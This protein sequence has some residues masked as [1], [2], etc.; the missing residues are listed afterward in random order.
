M[1]VVGSPSAVA[2]AEATPEGASSAALVVHEVATAVATSVAPVPTVAAPRRAVAY[3]LTPT[4]GEGTRQVVRATAR[5][6]TPAPTAS[7]TA[8]AGVVPSVPSGRGGQVLRTC[9]ARAYPV[10]APRV[11]LPARP[12]AMTV[13]PS[14]PTGVGAV[15]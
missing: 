13:A 8:G 3:V 5:A 12:M 14:V 11:P 15:A 10:V 1:I 7:L 6:A 2:V 4:V 9:H